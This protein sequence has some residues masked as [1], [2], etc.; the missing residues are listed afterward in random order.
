MLG[1][2]TNQSQRD[3]FRPLLSDFISMKHGLVRLVNQTSYV[4]SK[5]TV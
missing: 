3:L 1:K 4:F 5:N 2:S